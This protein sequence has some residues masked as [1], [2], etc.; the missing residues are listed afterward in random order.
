MKKVVQ[1]VLA[2]LIVVL[3]YVLI[4]MIR[5][6]LIFQRETA[7]RSAA[8]IERIKDIR[9]AQR[10]YRQAHGEFTPSFD[11]LINF[12]LNDSIRFMR[13]VGSEDDSLAVAQGRVYREPFMKAVIDTVF[14]A[15]IL[16][17]DQVRELPLI[18]FGN[19]ARYIMDAGTV[20]TAAQ[21][22]VPVFECKAPYISFL[23]DLNEQQLINLIDNAKTLNRYP[24]I[25]VGSLTEATNE[26]GNWE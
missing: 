16:T 17:R 19:G 10:A 2:V 7:V 25:K 3:V 9:S 4:N 23:R 14:G 15:K 18:P 1:I 5:Q 6:P 11:T 12:I 8:V 24:G 22:A 20:L 21:I 26:A 13:M